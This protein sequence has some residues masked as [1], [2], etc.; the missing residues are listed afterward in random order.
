MNINCFFKDVLRRLV[1]DYLIVYVLFLAIFFSP[2]IRVSYSQETS[3]VTDL[4]SDNPQQKNI[5]L[6]H[7][8]AQQPKYPYP[9]QWREKRNFNRK[10]LYAPVLDKSGNIYLAFPDGTLTAVDPDGNTKWNIHMGDK[11]NAGFTIGSDN[12]LYFSSGKTLYAISSSGVLKWTFNADNMIDSPSVLDNQGNVYVVTKKDNF[13]YAIRNDGSLY[14][15][16]HINNISTHP[17]VAH[18]GIIYITTRGSTLYAINS[19]GSLRW[20]RE[21]YRRKMDQVALVSETV[22]VGRQE[23]SYQSKEK[24]DLQKQDAQGVSSDPKENPE[25]IQVFPRETDTPASTDFESL[26]AKGGTPLTVGFADISSDK[27]AHRLE[28]SGDKTQQKQNTPKTSS[29]PRE[30]TEEIQALSQ[31]T[32]TPVSTSFEASVCSGSSPLTVRFSDSSSG[33]V[34]NRL[35]DFGDGS[36]ASA[37]QQPIHR[38]MKPGNYDIRL[39]VRRPDSTLT[40]VRQGYIVVTNPRGLNIN[41][42]NTSA[43]ERDIGI[44]SDTQNFLDDAK[45]T[46]ETF[47]SA[48]N[49]KNP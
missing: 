37:E 38:Y 40:V 15:K 48:V 18:N 32:D 41:E 31:G 11:I 6:P 35:W 16:V 34:I 47:I 8:G 1:H 3:E 17:S 43:K 39:I 21:V 10:T 44:P 22:D 13:L 24:D 23:S 2:A 7:R 12:A 33:K 19:E 14:W 25:E 5:S 4:P 36:L 42:N 45:I 28:D 30:K 29:M 26:V 9:S 20:K 49:P 46:D 27:V